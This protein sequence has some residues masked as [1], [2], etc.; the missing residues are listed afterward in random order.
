MKSIVNRTLGLLPVALL[1]GFGV[2]VFYL[3]AIMTGYHY[4]T[5]EHLPDMSG[6]L[7]GFDR[8]TEALG[9]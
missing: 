3:I 7:T 6:I 9:N 2:G 5:T 4:Y 1:L 8:L